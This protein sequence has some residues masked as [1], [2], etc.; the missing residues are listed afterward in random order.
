M[1]IRV[2]I[3]FFGG[4]YWNGGI[5]FIESIA[6]NLSLLPENI[7]PE[8]FLIISPSTIKNIEYIAPSIHLFSGVILLRC[9]EIRP[10]VLNTQIY[11]IYRFE[12]ISEYI[13][14]IFP[15]NTEYLNGYP[16]LS[17]L[18][19][20]QHKKLPGLFSEKDIADRNSRLSQM[21]NFAE[22]IIVNCP[23]VKNDLLHYYPDYQGQVHIIPVYSYIDRRY[24][25]QD[26][27]ETLDKYQITGNYIIC[28]NQFWRHKNH[29][30]LIKALA[31]TK[32]PIHLVLTGS[33]EDYRCDKW[34]DELRVLI[35]RENLQNRISI[36]G[37]IPRADQIQL[38]R[39]ALA[40]VQPSLF[41]GWSM[42]L[43]EAR[44]LGKTILASDINAHK[45]RN[46]ENCNLF[47]PLNINELARSIDSLYSEGANIKYPDRKSELIAKNNVETLA[48]NSAQD[49]LGLLKKIATE[50]VQTISNIKTA[51]NNLLFKKL[52]SNII[53]LN[54]VV[55]EKEFVIGVHVLAIQEARDDI[56]IK[57]AAI[58]E[59]HHLSQLHIQYIEELKLE[60]KN[61]YIIINAFSGRAL[62]LLIKLLNILRTCKN[63][64][65]YLMRAIKHR[66][67]Y[68]LAG[69]K[70]Y[71]FHCLRV[72]KHRILYFPEEIKYYCDCINAKYNKYLLKFFR[73]KLGHLHIHDPKSLVFKSIYSKSYNNVDCLT[74][75]IVTPSYMQGKYLESTIQ[76]VLDQKYPSLEY[77]IQDGGSTDTSLNI[78][79]TYAERIS[80]Y[81]SQH[82]LGQTN[83]INQGMQKTSGE[84]MAWINSDDL[85]APGTFHEI[86]LYF[87]NNPNIDVV[88]GNRV[89]IDENNFEIGRWHMPKHDSEILSWVDFIPQETLFWRRSAWEK[90]GKSL[91]EDFKFAMDWD[92]ITR[93]RDAGANFARI[94]RVL[95]CFRVHKEQ[96]TSALI[97]R[98][99]AIEMNRIR[100]KYLGYIPNDEEI[101]FHIKPYLKKHQIEDFK[102][103]LLSLLGR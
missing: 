60:I 35:A 96:K 56:K 44:I 49:M 87:K 50:Y 75:S 3:P 7:R 13:D 10:Y 41:E 67:R 20:L 40:M 30:N 63:N 36:L 89:L 53:N 78:L 28:C 99:G 48:K 72:I 26:P 81:V 59:Q 97:S 82:D 93:F 62:K 42:V 84:I 58:K 68:A 54:E 32:S 47:N 12:D 21:M 31:L 74:I 95:G 64:S 61:N 88:Y 2:G 27:I 25:S 17:W 16:C 101:Y 83:A 80:G 51:K 9:A 45:N 55:I 34:I 79:E 85:Y 77:F 37:Y 90:V 102:I 14:V 69:A 6:F 18:P 91:N 92:L 1:K 66:V 23:D 38:I 15:I 46:I 86:A 65:L 98:D 43:E 33:L 70:H 57:D 24:L 39:G 103:R 5:S 94:P 73:I 71:T 19:D 52:N 29:N 22:D 8:L 11:E 76:S 100:Q 4:N